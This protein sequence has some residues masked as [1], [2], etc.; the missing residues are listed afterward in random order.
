[1]PTSRTGCKQ[2]MQRDIIG[3]GLSYSRS[4][5]ECSYYFTSRQY[6][7]DT[8]VCRQNRYSRV[9]CIQPQG[10]SMNKP[11][12]QHLPMPGLPVP[13]SSMNPLPGASSC[14][15]MDYL[16]SLLPYRLHGRNPHARVIRQQAFSTPTPSAKSFQFVLY[17][18]NRNDFR[19]TSSLTGKY[20]RSCT[21]TPCRPKVRAQ[22]DPA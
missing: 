16:L 4:D 17:F 15:Y 20:G 8:D 22:G 5:T 7:R 14:P 9:C 3:N 21:H 2:K 10:F 1:M 19:P 18:P 12:I 13:D 11:R 6:E